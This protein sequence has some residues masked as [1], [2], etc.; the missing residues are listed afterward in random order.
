MYTCMHASS[1]VDFHSADVWSRPRHQEWWGG[2][3]A[4]TR[5]EAVGHYRDQWLGGVPG[6]SPKNADF[7]ELQW[8]FNG[9]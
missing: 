2:T 8:W 7:N 9:G 1:A 5:S 4:E 3:P 6:G